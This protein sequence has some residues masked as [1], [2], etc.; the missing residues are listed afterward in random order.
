MNLA[1]V[2]FETHP[3]GIWPDDCPKPVGVAIMLE[4]QAPEYLAWGHEGGVNNTTKE[5]ATARL[6]DLYRQSEVIF[7]N[8]AFDLE[9]GA[10]H[11]GIPYPAQFHDTMI[12]AFLH[13]PYAKALALKEAADGLLGTRPEE[14]DDLREWVLTHIPGARSAPS[15]WGSFI[16]KTPAN[17]TGAYACGD[18]RRTLGLYVFLYPRIKHAGML[19][20]YDRELRLLPILARMT[21]AGIPIA[22]RRLEAATAGWEASRD[23]LEHEIRDALGA[24]ALNLNSPGQLADALEAAGK[25][26]EFLRTAKGHRS[27]SREA[28]AA[29]VTD[30][31]LKKLLN[32]RSDIDNCLKN[33]MPMLA[34]S[35]VD[36]RVHCEWNG[37]RHDNGGARTGRIIS[38]YPNIQGSPAQLRTFIIPDPGGVLLDRDFTQQELRIFAHFE[39]GEVKALYL[40]D[41]SIDFHTMTAS[42]A[43][44]VLGRELSRKPQRS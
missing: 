18:V 6:K 24:P 44:A 43:S 40:A 29:V 14:R 9:V 20:A 10:R 8:A 41:P 13:N 35:S 36:G 21:N 38:K 3:I 15:R 27:F 11:L 30:A 7:H 25:V 19:A 39:D 37:T 33:A 22:R 32:Q 12:L 34:M 4:G 31:N 28:L 26:K 17:I 2:D 1:A 5:N 16:A 42:R 23:Q